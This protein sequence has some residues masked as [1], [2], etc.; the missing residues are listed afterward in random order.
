MPP[1]TQEEAGHMAICN[2]AAWDSKVAANA[3]WVYHD[4]VY[5]SISISFLSNICILAK[6]F[7]YMA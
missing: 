1:K 5:K 4:Q 6:K 3:Y 2:S 7:L